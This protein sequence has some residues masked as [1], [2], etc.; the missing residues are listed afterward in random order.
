M[1]FIKNLQTYR[2]VATPFHMIGYCI[3]NAKSVMSFLRYKYYIMNVVILTPDAVGST[4]LQRMLTIYMQFHRFDQ[5]VINLHELTNGLSR[6][7]SPEFNRELVGKKAVKN[8]GYYQSL[9]EIV[10]LLSSVDHYKTSRLA[11]YHIKQRGDSVA[12]QLPFYNY[13][14]EN[15]YIIAC[16]RTNVFE[17][18]LSMTLNNITKKL[19]VYNA[20]E[21]IDAFY[22]IYKTGVTLDP[23]VFAAKLNAYKLYI[24]W[25]QQHFNIGSYFN[26]EQNIPGLEQYILDLPVFAGQ[27]ELVTWQKNFGLS[28][29]NWNKLHYA[30]SD[31]GSI[32]LGHRSDL[33]PA[34]L[35]TPTNDTVLA[36]QQLAPSHWPEV[37]SV[38]D[39]IDLPSKI[40]NQLCQDLGLPK[41]I[42]SLLPA[43]RQQD[44]QQ[45]QPGYDL[46]Q[47]TIGQMVGLGIMINGPPIKKQTLADKLKTI[48]NFDQLINVYNKWIEVNPEIAVPLTKEGI[49]IRVQQEN[50]FWNLTPKLISN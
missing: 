2:A 9:E 45:Y 11:H 38:Q 44:L 37:H 46:A 41:G 32:T 28:F 48:K 4:L 17:H 19:N 14:N 15:F 16:R 30:H 5:P 35:F 26:Y 22:D 29:D 31:I 27:P 7:Y 20:Y 21:K 24:N 25:S 13:L 6:Y 47:H 8:W 1:L 49:D 34:L 3:T 50:Q 39:I 12:D 33:A 42:F 40:K 43:N 10:N 23:A 18:A 36:Y